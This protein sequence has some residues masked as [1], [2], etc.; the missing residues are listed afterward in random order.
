VRK[1]DGSGSKGKIEHTAKPGKSRS[2]RG[3]SEQKKRNPNLEK[4]MRLI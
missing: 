1:A 2:S 4:Q 3:K